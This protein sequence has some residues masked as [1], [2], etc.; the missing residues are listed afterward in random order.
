MGWID[1]AQV[2]DGWQVHMNVV[3]NLWIPL[4]VGS[5]LTS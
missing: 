1:L 4:N 3:M 5:F 2:W